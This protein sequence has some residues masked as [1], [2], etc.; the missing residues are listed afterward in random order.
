MGTL[1]LL[2]ELHVVAFI[3]THNINHTVDHDGKARV[4]FTPPGAGDA[5]GELYIAGSCIFRELGIID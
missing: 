5:L 1:C 2:S 4:T 3:S